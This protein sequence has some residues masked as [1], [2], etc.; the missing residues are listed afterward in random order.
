MTSN[1]LLALREASSQAHALLHKSDESDVIWERALVRDFSFVA[2]D[3]ASAKRTIR[4]LPR[5]GPN[6]VVSIFGCSANESLF[7]AASC[8]SSWRHWRKASRRFYGQPE[9]VAS[10][11]VVT[12]RRNIHGPCKLITFWLPGQYC[13]IPGSFSY[14]VVYL[15]LAHTVSQISSE[16]P[17]F[18]QKLRCGVKKMMTWVQE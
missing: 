5:Q 3:D 13:K 6:T 11:G 17:L 8:F 14:D 7:T 1:D 10:D 16:L 15:S 12:E 2:G 4:V 9:I 18:G